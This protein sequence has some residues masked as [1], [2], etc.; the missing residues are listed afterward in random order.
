MSSS[1]LI[2]L[3]IQILQKPVR[4]QSPKVH[5]MNKES[6]E[7]QMQVLLLLHT[8]L[9]ILQ[10]KLTRFNLIEGY[11]YREDCKNVVNL[12]ILV[13]KNDQKLAVCR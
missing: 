12:I 9:N 7:Y 1:F 4:F 5:S 3:Y 2:F 13:I 10:S 11:I 6:A 8:Y